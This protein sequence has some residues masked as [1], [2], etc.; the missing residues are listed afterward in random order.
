MLVDVFSE[1]AEIEITN[2]ISKNKKTF[3]TA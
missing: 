3:E 2:A 1:N